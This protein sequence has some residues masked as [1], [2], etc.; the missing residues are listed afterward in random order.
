MVD[1]ATQAT[2]T[3]ERIDIPTWGTVTL[4]VANP[5]EGPD[6]AD[7]IIYGAFVV[8]IGGF[9]ADQFEDEPVT[10]HRFYFHVTHVAS[11]YAAAID[12][13]N[14]EAHYLAREFAACPAFVAL[15]DARGA[16]GDMKMTA[17]L[18]EWFRS[19]LR[20]A[21]SSYGAYAGVAR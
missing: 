20:D 1:T 6:T 13:E 14:R 8:H 9:D 18:A 12:L 4:A 2:P 19:T 3:E 17:E 15:C 7:A 5:G 10:N 11:G 21:A 16:G